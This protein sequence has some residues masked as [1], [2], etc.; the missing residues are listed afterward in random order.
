MPGMTDNP[1]PFAIP[2]IWIT[3]RYPDAENLSQLATLFVV[4]FIL[5]MIVRYYPMQWTA[6]IHGQ[7]SDAALPTLLTA[8]DHIEALFPAL[9]VDFIRE[10]N[11][12][13]E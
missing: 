8:V 1:G 2:D 6:L 5:G 9:A 4:A 7:F 3:E 10:T 13:S 12:Q 11:W